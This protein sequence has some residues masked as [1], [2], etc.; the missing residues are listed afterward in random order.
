MGK[1]I[2]PRRWGWDG[3]SNY[4][5]SVNS[6]ACGACLWS[7]NETFAQPVCPI[8]CGTIIH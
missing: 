7:G 3:I 4:T 1:R 2:W 5:E 8:V 6:N